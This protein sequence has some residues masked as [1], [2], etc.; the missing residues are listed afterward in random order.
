MG[1]RYGIN[2]IPDTGIG[3]WSRREVSEAQFIQL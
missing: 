1:Y 3:R 2:L